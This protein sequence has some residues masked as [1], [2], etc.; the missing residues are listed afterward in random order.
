MIEGPKI[1]KKS[2]PVLKEKI[3]EKL[4]G[5]EI[6]SITFIACVGIS[7]LYKYGFYSELGITWFSKTLS[8]Q[9]LLISSISYVVFSLVGI[10]MGVLAIHYADKYIEPVMVGMFVVLLVA[11]FLPNYYLLGE[12]KNECAIMVYFAISSLYLTKGNKGVVNAEG[13]PLDEVEWHDRTFFEKITPSIFVIFL[14]ILPLYFIYDQ[15]RKDAQNILNKSSKINFV[16]LK[17]DKEFWT[18]IEMNGDKILIMKDG[19]NREF[20]IVEY[21][22][23]ESIK[24][25]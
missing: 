1:I 23:I 9:V 10:L 14:A 12:L 25:N 20:K 11:G 19:G 24:V 22:E 3:L 18:L 2:T 15:G 17:N 21:K 13:K 8:P 4:S 5:A 6:L 16:K 7:L